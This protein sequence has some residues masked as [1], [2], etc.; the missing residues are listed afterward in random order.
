[1]EKGSRA[2]LG[3]RRQEDSPLYADM[4]AGKFIGA[5]RGYVESSMYN[6]SVVKE[7]KSS[8]VRFKKGPRVRGKGWA[9]SGFGEKEQPSKSHLP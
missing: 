3:L 2:L 8:F 5:G 1:M 7:V 9:V 4:Q 6:K